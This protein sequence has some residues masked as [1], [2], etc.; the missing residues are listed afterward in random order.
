[1]T[2]EQ[3]QQL[4]GLFLVN[5]P[6]VVIILLGQ[7]RGWWIDGK[8]HDREI[9]E[10]DKFIAFLTELWKTALTDK[11]AVEER[12][13]KQSEAMKELTSVVRESLGFQKELVDD[14]RQGSWDRSPD[15]RNQPARARTRRQPRS[16]GRG[17]TTS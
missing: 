14:A 13:L 6:F 2:P 11:I 17:T 4:I 9:A 7:R 8:A 3:T 10:K 5:L 15:R 1:M 16:D 12:S